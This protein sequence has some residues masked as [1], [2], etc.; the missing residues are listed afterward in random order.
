LYN[1]DIF[2]YRG[3]GNIHYLRGH[4]RWHWFKISGVHTRMNQELFLL[5]EEHHNQLFAWNK[6]T[7]K[8]LG[9]SSSVTGLFQRIAEDIEEGVEV[10]LRCLPED[11]GLIIKDWAERALDDLVKSQDSKVLDI[12]M[13]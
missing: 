5:V 3:H 2:K 11:G 13:E 1:A 7:N 12:R 4:I 9:Q 10:G 8:F 6:K